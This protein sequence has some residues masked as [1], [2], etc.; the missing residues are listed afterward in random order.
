MNRTM[1]IPFQ[2]IVLRAKEGPLVE[3]KQFDLGL[4]KKTQSLQKEYRI[5]YDP[6][7]PPDISFPP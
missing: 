1:R 6:Q 3:E 2:E 4:F 5:K 7:A